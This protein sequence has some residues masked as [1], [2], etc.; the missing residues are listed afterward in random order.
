[1]YVLEMLGQTRIIASGGASTDLGTLLLA[2]S[3]VDAEPV[4]PGPFRSL[5]AWVL[6]ALDAGVGS[7]RDVEHRRHDLGTGSVLL[8]RPGLGHW[9]G[10]RPGEVWTETWA[11][12]RGPVFDLLAGRLD[13][14]TPLRQASPAQRR[15]LL[16]LLSVTTRSGRDHERQLLD[17]L[18]WLL[19]VV[20]PASAGRDPVIQQAADLLDSDLRAEWTMPELARQVGVDYDAFR[21]RFAAAL[22]APP[23]A[24]RNRRRLAAAAQLLRATNLTLR[25]IARELGFTDEFH[26]SRSFRATYGVP[27]SAYRRAGR[28]DGRG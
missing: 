18:G 8:I 1:M 17:L 28:D 11:I 25:A 21:H 22:G 19:E 3:V 26:L 15:A 10:T 14:R 24:Y 5:D 16:G 20:D 9:Y 2:G 6:V 12:F 4:V 13:E 7:Y 27:P 23:A